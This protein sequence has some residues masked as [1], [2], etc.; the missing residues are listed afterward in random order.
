MTHHLFTKLKLKKIVL[1]AI[2]SLLIVSCKNDNKISENIVKHQNGATVSHV[3]NVDF[4]AKVDGKN[5]QL[6]DVRT[7]GEYNNGHLKNAILIDYKDANFV[8]NA[9]QK[10]DKS[11]PVFVYCHSGHRSANSAELLKKEGY[12]VYNMKGGI[13]GWNAN[14]FQIVKTDAKKPEDKEVDKSNAKSQKVTDS[15]TVV[16]ISETETK[17]DI[18]ES[19]NAPEKTTDNQPTN[20]VTEKEVVTKETVKEVKEIVVKAVVETSRPIQKKPLTP[21]LIRSNTPDF[22][23]KIDGKNVQLIDVRTPKEFKDGHIPKAKNINIYDA[24]F[25]KQTN[26]LDK[27]KPVYVYCRSGVRSMKAAKKLK[28]AGYKVYNLNDGIKG[29]QR[30]GHKIEK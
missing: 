14:H 23:A 28:N 4:K 13:L 10:L 24:D 30:E 16:P 1:I 3:S 6:V 29:W 18:K 22:K 12:T 7:P 26:V 17:V 11:K 19:V 9:I 21:E 20:P 15:K 8:K 27:S 2:G 5:V 25:M